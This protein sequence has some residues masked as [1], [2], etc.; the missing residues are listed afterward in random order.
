M[1]FSQ[2]EIVRFREKVEF[3]ETQECW[4]WKGA[5][6]QNGY[7]QV[8]LRRGKRKTFSAHRI[9][10]IMSNK[11]SIPDGLMICH[12][13][14][15]RSCVNPNHLY[16]GTGKDN[17]TDTVKRN[18]GNRK[19]GD[20]CSWSKLTEDQVAEILKSNSRQ[21]DLAIEYGVTQPTISQIKTGK[22]R[23]NLMSTSLSLKLCELLETP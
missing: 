1:H 16:A 22:R 21:V 4:G 11:I 20:Q 17:N 15:N 14:D 8:S 19:I 23:R 7:G 10:W 5:R 9:S 12:T 3:G 2:D 18:R 13:C 6:Y